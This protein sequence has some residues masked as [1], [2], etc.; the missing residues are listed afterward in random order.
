MIR[1]CKWRFGREQ[2]WLPSGAEQAKLWSWR[3]MCKEARRGTDGE[4]IEI[5]QEW[6]GQ[7]KIIDRIIN[8]FK[9]KEN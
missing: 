7:D 4:E 3:A 9:A 2:T 6:Q 5:Q 8:K 1:L